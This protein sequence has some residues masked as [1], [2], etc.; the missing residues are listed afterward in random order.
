[1]RW[2]P[3]AL[4]FGVSFAAAQNTPLPA[5]I[6]DPGQKIRVE[7]TILSV[8]GDLIRKATVRLQGGA[9]QPG[10]P[11]TSYIETTDNAGKFVFDDVAPGRYTL[12]A[13]KP[14]FVAARYGARSNTSI[15]T[16][17]NLTAGMAMKDLAIKMTPQGVIAGKVVDQDGDPMISVQIQAMRFGYIGG[18]K[19]LQPASGTSTNDLGEYRL[20]NL[21]PGHYF[22]SATDNRRPIQT[23]AQERPGRAGTVQEGNITTYYPNGADISSAVA[24]DVAAGAETRGTD[25]RLLQAKVYTVRGKT[26]DASGGP[27]TAFLQLIRK[28]SGGNLPTFLNGGGSSQVRPDGTFEFRSILPGTYIVQLAQI[29]SVNGNPAADLTG[30]MEVTVGDAD[31]DN[32]VLPLVPHP[33]ITGTVTL[34]DGDLASLIKPAQNTPGAAV[35]GNAVRPQPGRLALMLLPTE[36]LPTAGTSPA[37]VKEDGTFL[38]S[39]V[40]LGKYALNL[41]SL[42]QGT[43]LKSARFAG[44]DVTKSLIDT[45]SGTGGRLELVLSSKSADITGSVQNDKGETRSGVM[46]TLWPKIPDPSPI[47]GARPSITDQNGGFQFKGLAPGDYYIAAWED[48]DLGLFQSTEFL[49]HFTSEATSVTLSES[50]HEN[51]EVKIVPA[52]K[53]AAEVAKL[54]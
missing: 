8:N 7:G 15:G 44:Q 3:L 53:V 32:L 35:S 37:Q 23:F 29:N 34:E 10:Q 20:I 16:Q 46:V 42:P 50:G 11:P 31:V 1:M 17:L 4:L 43:Y 18:R 51:R 25:I 21:A 36:G 26:A 47:G 30:R 19:Q 14:G 13:E 6:A 24:V 40:G 54:Q 41:N 45:T 28:D 12:S 49:N 52:D 22:I 2:F 9:S 48:V 39:G 38:F 27:L 33:E 5:P